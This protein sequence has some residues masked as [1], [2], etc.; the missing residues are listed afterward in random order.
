[1]TFKLPVVTVDTIQ[2]HNSVMKAQ[3]NAYDVYKAEIEKITKENPE[4]G[5]LI[6]GLYKA[7]KGTA[8]EQSAIFMAGLY[9]LLTMQGEI[10]ETTKTLN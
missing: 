6:E 7:G 8:M 2:K 10:N 4:V 3:G 1:M 5:L 9:T